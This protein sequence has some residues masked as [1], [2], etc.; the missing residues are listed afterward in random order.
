MRFIT[1]TFFA[2]VASLTIRPA[3]AQTL[4]TCG[5]GT[6]R[7]VQTVVEM[8]AGPPVVTTSDRW[9]EPLQHVEMLP[10]VPR[11][12]YVV[13]VQLFDVRYTAEAFTDARENIDPTQLTENEVLSICV[14]R[15]RMT[16]ARADGTGFRANI[17]R[18]ERIKRAKTTH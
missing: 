8:V 1:I 13:T 6:F 3:E 14:S 12:A 7:T 18:V 16:L 10:A 4:Y 2:L 15:D 11:E 5:D 17:V 9:G